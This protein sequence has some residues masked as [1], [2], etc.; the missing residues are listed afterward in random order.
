M[1][2]IKQISEDSIEIDGVKYYRET[3]PEPPKTPKWENLELVKGW[4]VNGGS[5]I[6][7]AGVTDVS[8]D[9]RNIFPTHKHAE[10][11]IALA[12]LLQLRDSKFYRDG[13]KP[14]W[15]D[16]ERKYFVSCNEECLIVDWWTS[17]KQIF[18]F[19]NE[20]TTERFIE[21]Q[22]DLLEIFFGFYD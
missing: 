8:P 17:D 20:E 2:E 18:S 6:V 3:Q 13:W 21:E 7:V 19:Q 10:A 22:R 14:D 9:N 11:S 15:D 5:D 1:K 4:F 12:Q 16:Q